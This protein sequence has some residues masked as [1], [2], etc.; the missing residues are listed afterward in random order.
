MAKSLRR[1]KGLT[2]LALD[3]NEIS[4][5][6]IDVLKVRWQMERLAFSNPNLCLQAGSTALG[7]QETLEAA[8]QLKALGPLDDNDPDAADGDSDDDAAGEEDDE[9]TA[10][11]AKT[12]LGP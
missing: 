6:G 12:G 10:A 4:D 1:S 9:L 2:L 8:G 3:E 5:A 7:V 11:F